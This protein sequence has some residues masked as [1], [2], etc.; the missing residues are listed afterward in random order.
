[1]RCNSNRNKMIKKKV[2]PVAVGNSRL[3]LILTG[4]FVLNILMAASEGRA[5]GI[6]WMI[7]ITL[8]LAFIYAAG[9]NPLVFLGLDDRELFKR[10]VVVSLILFA[11]VQLYRFL[12]FYLVLRRSI[13]VYDFMD[14]LKYTWQQANLLQGF[15]EEILFRLWL[16][17]PFSRQ[18]R[19]R[20][21]LVNLGQTAAFC[22]FHAASV[23]YLIFAAGFSLAAGYIVGKTRSVIPSAL[24]HGFARLL[25]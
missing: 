12:L 25:A 3:F 8:V 21:W 14:R 15:G 9:E 4:F 6:F 1:M 17:L 23:P 22:L 2:P 18:S 20:F 19:K 24:V 16:L 11:G 13:P 5:N 10:L 7:I